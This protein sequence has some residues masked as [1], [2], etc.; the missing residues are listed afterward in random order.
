[1]VLKHNIVG[2]DALLYITCENKIAYFR[3]SW[4]KIICNELIFTIVMKTSRLIVFLFSI[5][6]ER[7]LSKNS[8]NLVERK[9]HLKK[10]MLK[11]KIQN[12][13]IPDHSVTNAV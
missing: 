4:A 9:K 8:I 10:K 5:E 11:E 2:Y 7:K 3:Y 1:M 13:S 12:A 6:D